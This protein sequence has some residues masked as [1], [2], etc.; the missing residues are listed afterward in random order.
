MTRFSEPW[1]LNEA[2]ALHAVREKAKENWTVWFNPNAPLKSSL[3]KVFPLGLFVRTFI[4]YGV[5]IYFV[6]IFRKFIRNSYK[7]TYFVCLVH[8]FLA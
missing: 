6:I 7:L 8:D 2:S 5:L 1:H 3:E 4:C